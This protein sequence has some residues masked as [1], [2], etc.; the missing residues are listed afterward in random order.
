MGYFGQY[1]H[2]KILAQQMQAP[3]SVLSNLFGLQK[4]VFLKP[5]ATPVNLKAMT[6][7]YWTL[8]TVLWV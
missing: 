1:F 2:T 6:T 3:S 8:L 4:K 5:W 7:I